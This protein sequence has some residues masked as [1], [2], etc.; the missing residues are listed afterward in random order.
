[1]F[2]SLQYLPWA[3]K[4][5]YHIDM[6]LVT[7]TMAVSYSLFSN[8]ILRLVSSSLSKISLDNDFDTVFDALLNRFIGMF[9]KFSMS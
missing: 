9:P 6:R 3:G 4:E 7:L 2:G 8:E 1:M 5:I